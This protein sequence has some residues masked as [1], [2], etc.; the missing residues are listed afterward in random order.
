MD[1]NNQQSIE[2]TL[3]IYGKYDDFCA[4]L[5]FIRISKR[6][7]ISSFMFKAQKIIIQAKACPE[8]CIKGKQVDSN[9]R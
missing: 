2:E 9:R 5:N 6:N 8:L 7:D 4:I 1:A 3:K